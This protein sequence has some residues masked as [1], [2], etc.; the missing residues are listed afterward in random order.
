M[1]LRGAHYDPARGA[2]YSRMTSPQKVRA[3]RIST[4]R[5]NARARASRLGALTYGENQRKPATLD[6]GLHSPLSQPFARPSL[7]C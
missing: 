6:S 2:L 4:L 5:L 3:V 1:I 7:R